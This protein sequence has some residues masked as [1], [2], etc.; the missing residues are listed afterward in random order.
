MVI[1]P[2]SVNLMGFFV[3]ARRYLTSSLWTGFGRVT[4]PTTRGTFAS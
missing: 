2:G 4:G 1:G 3:A